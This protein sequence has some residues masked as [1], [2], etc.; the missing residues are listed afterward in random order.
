MSCAHMVSSQANVT[1]KFSCEMNEDPGALTL[2]AKTHTSP[3]FGNFSVVIPDGTSR[4]FCT[5]IKQC[6]LSIPTD[7][8]PLIMISGKP[9]S[10][11]GPLVMVLASYKSYQHQPFCMSKT[12]IMQFTILKNAPTPVDHKVICSF[13]WSVISL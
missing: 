2:R 3:S 12:V 11:A 6:S 4:M 13:D 7:F 8:I 1:Q 9:N 10:L 5:S